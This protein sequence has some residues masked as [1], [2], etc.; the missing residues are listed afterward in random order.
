M[1]NDILYE[2][3]WDPCNLPIMQ[4]FTSGYAL[5]SDVSGMDGFQVGFTFTMKLP[6]LL[7]CGHRSVN[8]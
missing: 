5:S 4:I 3:C 7:R 6:T 2:F 8:Q 1:K